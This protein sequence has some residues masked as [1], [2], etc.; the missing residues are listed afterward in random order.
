VPQEP[1]EHHLVDA[2]GSLIQEENTGANLL[3]RRRRPVRISTR[4]CW[5]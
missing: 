5:R 2:V 3:D 1:V 4:C